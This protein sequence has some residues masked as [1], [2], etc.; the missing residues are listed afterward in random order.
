MKMLKNL[1]FVALSLA[2]FASCNDDDKAPANTS[3][4]KVAIKTST[5]TPAGSAS[6]KNAAVGANTLSLSE[7]YINIA[8]IE[9]DVDDDMRDKLPGNA[10][11]Y[12][13]VELDGPFVVNLLDPKA[14]TGIDLATANIP[15]ATYEEIEFEFDKYNGTDKKFENLKG[16]TIYAAGAFILGDETIDF[17]IKSDE[18]WEIELEYEDGGIVLDGT[19]SKVF[20][21]LNLEVLIQ[22]LITKAAPDFETAV[23]ETDGSILISKDKNKAI[24]KKFEDAVEIAFD[25][26][27][28]GDDD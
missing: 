28:D 16:N 5:S 19:A 25:A 3:R 12:G 8:E 26:F 23:R 6:L 13:D 1:F 21:D 18:E 11:V 24:L 9:F 22:T 4:V 10:P 20:I 17:V 15:N 2:V 14:S 7:L 27:E